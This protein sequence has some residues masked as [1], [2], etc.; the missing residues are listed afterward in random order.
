MK[1]KNFEQ[2]APTA[3]DLDQHGCCW[4]GYCCPLEGQYNWWY[5]NVQGQ[6]GDW[7]PYNTPYLPAK[8]VTTDQLE[9]LL[10][11]ELLKDLFTT[12]SYGNTYCTYESHIDLTE[13]LQKLVE[14]LVQHFPTVVE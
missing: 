1:V 13:P 7:L 8:P 12:D 2:E 5:G 10:K 11:A 14:N 9:Q 3:K 6:V 4:I